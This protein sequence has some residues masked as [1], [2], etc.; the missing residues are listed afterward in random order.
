[1]RVVF[2][3]GN[4]HKADYFSRQM[5]M[6]VP[7]QKIDLEEIQSLDIHEIV[8]HKLRQ[9]YEAVG[10][11][12]I[13]EDVSLGYSALNGLPGPYIRWFTE[14]AGPEAC[15]RM[16]DAYEDRSAEIQCT[17]GYYDGENMKF[18]DSK[19][20]GR[21]SQKPSGANGFGFDTFFIMDGYDITRAEM[22]Q[23]E[24]ERTYAEN[25]KP[26]AKVRAFLESIEVK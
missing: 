16:L 25:M 9:A 6:D 8:T 26:F 11:P 13:V 19:M 15:C 20:K 17:F 24:V 18:F 1:M 22:S 12:V 21:I 4:S 14:N 23:D 5:G 10:V 2:I 3:T 7:H